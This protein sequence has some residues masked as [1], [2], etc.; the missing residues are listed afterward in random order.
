MLFLGL[1]SC[2]TYHTDKRMLPDPSPSDWVTV[3]QITTTV[4]DMEQGFNLA[5]V[6]FIAGA[7]NVTTED[8][9]GLL[10]PTE[11]D[12]LDFGQ[13]GFDIIRINQLSVC[14][15]GTDKCTEARIIVYVSSANAGLYN[16]T[17]GYSVPMYINGTTG[18]G[19][20]I[21]NANELASYSIPASDRKLTNTDF[22]TVV[23]PLT[24]DF[25]NGGAG[26]YGASITMAVQ[27]Q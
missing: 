9:T 6:T 24:A 10:V 17:D 3:G 11:A 23:W 7:S 19:H 21:G 27:V 25:S 1:V 14:G 18:I 26:S 12:T 16:N 4:G 13:Y 22:G 5:D 20:L 15:T 8:S 2:G